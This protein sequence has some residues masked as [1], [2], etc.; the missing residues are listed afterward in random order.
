V[1]LHIFLASSDVVPGGKV[2]SHAFRSQHINGGEGL[3]CFPIFSFGVLS[4]K[5][6]VLCYI[7]FRGPRC[8]CNPI[9]NECSFLIFETLPCWK[10]RTDQFR[11]KRICFCLFRWCGGK[12]AGSPNNVLHFDRRHVS[13]VNLLFFSSISFS[14]QIPLSKKIYTWVY[15]P[16][17]FWP[18]PPPHQVRLLIQNC[19]FKLITELL[20][21][22]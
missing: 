17:I 11:H 7:S 18:P 20:V 13:L 6:W 21:M 12:Y 9:L 5:I 19:R 3:D 10:N 8:N 1:A 22:Q 2:D 15:E 14:L 16:V 4:K